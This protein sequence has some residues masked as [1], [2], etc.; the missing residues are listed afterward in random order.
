VL[1]PAFHSATFARI[2]GTG[3]ISAPVLAGRVMSFAIIGLL[4]T[5]AFA[6]LYAALRTAV[7]PLPANAVALALTMTANFAANRRFTFAAHAGPLLPQLGGYLVVY[8]AGLGAS[9][10][11]LLLA[12]QLFS[13]PGAGLETIIAVACGGFATLT[14]FVFLSAWVFRP[15]HSTVSEVHHG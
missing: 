1:K 4:C 3:T 10:L 7:A 14:R 15:H 6:G 13:Q 12:L 9:S 8:A 11:A 2:S 5:F